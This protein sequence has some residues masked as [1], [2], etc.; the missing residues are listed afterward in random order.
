MHFRLLVDFAIR[1]ALE[2]HLPDFRYYN[3][4]RPYQSFNN[5]TPMEA[6]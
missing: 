1:C 2:I 4:Y 5:Q 3:R 6:I